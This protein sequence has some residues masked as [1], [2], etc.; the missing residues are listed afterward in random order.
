M[1]ESD[2]KPIRHEVLLPRREVLVVRGVV[3]GV[4]F[5]PF[6][7][8][9]AMEEKL[10]GSIGNDTGGV[11]IEIE[12]PAERVE[13]FRRRLEA[14]SPP[15]ARIDSV[16]V[17]ETLGHGRSRFSHYCQRG[18]RTRQYRNSRR[19][20]DLRRLPARTVRSQRPALSLSISE[21]HQLR[22]A[23]HHYT[24]HSLRSSA[25]L[26]GAL[27]HVRG[28]SGGVRRSHQPPFPRAT[29][30]LP[31]VRTAC[32]ARSERL[33]PQRCCRERARLQSCR[34]ALPQI[35]GLC[36]LQKNSVTRAL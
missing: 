28:L 4:G 12:G 6:V 15:L 14:E 13:A 1:R 33:K 34:K 27:Y 11:T 20:G 7:F 25:D 26:D 30:R 31:G 36:G 10:A 3:Q 5:R 29:Q 18:Q 24:P 35:R 16:A 17:R 23:L 9:L 2:S 32:L 8:R 21:L 19:R 22:S